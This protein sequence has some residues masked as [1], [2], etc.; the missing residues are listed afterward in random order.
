M[1][2]AVTLTTKEWIRFFIIVGCVGAVGNMMLLVI[3]D[4]LLGY[5]G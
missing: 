1:G 2:D 5:Y 4:W 3:I